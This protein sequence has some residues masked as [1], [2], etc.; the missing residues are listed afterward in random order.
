MAATKTMTAKRM[1][2]ADRSAAPTP[3]LLQTDIDCSKQ[4]KRKYLPKQR[5]PI[6]PTLMQLDDANS[7]RVHVL[8]LRSSIDPRAVAFNVAGSI[9]A[10]FFASS[11]PRIV[12]NNKTYL[13]DSAHHLWFA[14]D[15]VNWFCVETGRPERHLAM[16]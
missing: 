13:A 5:Q 8:I 3:K 7:V 15:A 12:P 11:L 1:K 4:Q 6:G 9:I 10:M 16:A 2:A 14:R